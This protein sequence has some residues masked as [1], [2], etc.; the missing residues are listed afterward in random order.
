[1]DT[2]LVK[3]GSE[4]LRS[5]SSYLS[6]SSII[7]S[8]SKLTILNISRTETQPRCLICMKVLWWF[9]FITQSSK[10]CTFYPYCPVLLCSAH[11][12]SNQLI[13]KSQVKT[14][15]IK[16]ATRPADPYKRQKSLH[17]SL[18]VKVS[19]AVMVLERFL[20]L[21]SHVIVFSWTQLHKCLKEENLR[22]SHPTSSFP[23]PW[24]RETIRHDFTC[25]LH[26]C[27]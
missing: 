15:T 20:L 18:S 25:F 14:N 17:I 6:H 3:W 5:D 24:M 26:V 11:Q 8:V 1:M 4:T 27:L 16:K 7:Y 22:I 19:E 13:D 12:L 2:S 23:S 21:L 9:T 10:F